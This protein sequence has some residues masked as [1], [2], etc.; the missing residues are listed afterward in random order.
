MLL[1]CVNQVLDSALVLVV[2]A[3]ILRQSSLL[4]ILAKSDSFL[5]LFK[6]DLEALL[7]EW[8]PPRESKRYS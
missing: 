5:F 1:D 3:L 6:C 4:A 7:I 2:K 8:K